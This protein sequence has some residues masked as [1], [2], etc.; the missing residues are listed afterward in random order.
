MTDLITSPESPHTPFYWNAHQSNIQPDENTLKHIKKH[1][2]INQSMLF[3]SR[4]YQT[5][6]NSARMP[7]TRGDI[8]AQHFTASH[9]KN[10][11]LFKLLSVSSSMNAPCKE[12]VRM[13]TWCLAVFLNLFR[14]HRKEL[15]YIYIY[16]SIS[17]IDTDIDINIE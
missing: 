2:N 10:A 11:S 3:I 8:V 7:K 6:L 15:R 17:I 5:I 14:T 12:D 13:Q 16:I 9:N 4:Q 1:L